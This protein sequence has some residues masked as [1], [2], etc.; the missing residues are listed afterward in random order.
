VAVSIEFEARNLLA[1]IKVLPADVGG[2]LKEI[3]KNF[4]ILFY[5]RKYVKL[6]I[7]AIKKF[8]H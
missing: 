2:F 7:V 5:Y 6:M 8:V 1:Q 3:V 4:T